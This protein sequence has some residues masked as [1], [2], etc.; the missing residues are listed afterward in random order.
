MQKQKEIGRERLKTLQICLERLNYVII[1]NYSTF[2]K[3]MTNGFQLKILIISTYHEISGLP[4]YRYSYLLII[5]VN[6][7]NILSIRKTTSIKSKTIQI[8]EA[9]VI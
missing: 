3:Q 2:L 9:M 7:I 5:Q 6:V 1:N 8:L 4:F